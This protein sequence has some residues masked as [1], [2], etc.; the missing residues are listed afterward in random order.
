MKAACK[1]RCKGY[2]N[3]ISIRM[4]KYFALVSIVSALSNLAAA[5]TKGVLKLH[6]QNNHYFLYK[7]KPTILVGSGEHYGAVLNLDFNYEKYLVSLAKDGLNTT[8]IFTGNYVEKSGD[9]GIQKNTLAPQSGSFIAPWKRSSVSGY[10]L[11][12]NKFD[13]EKWDEAYFKRLK[14][15][16]TK[17]GSKGIIVEITLFSSYYGKGWENS[18]LNH[19]NN[20]NKT[21]SIPAV[22]VNTLKNKNVIKFQEKFVRK[23]VREL[24][25]FDNLYFEIQNEPWA[26]FSETVIRRDDYGDEKDWRSTFQVVS[27]TSNE[28]QKTVASWI[29]DE[30]RILPNRHLISQNI[31]NFHYPIT[32]PD[33][34]VS[35]FN[36]HYAL[37]EAVKENYYLNKVIGF[38]ETG[39]AGKTDATYRKQAWRFLMSGGALFNHLDYSFAV[40]GEGGQD[41]VYKAPGG[42]SPTLRNELGFLKRFFESKNFINF[43]PD[44]NFVPSSPGAVALTLSN[45]TD[46]WIVYVEPVAPN[47]SS[48]TLNLPK[49][50]YQVDWVDAASGK[51]SEL[52]IITNNQVAVPAGL[53]DKVLFIRLKE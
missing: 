15:F 46:T 8:R 32:N 36:F 7:E 39:F 25:N 52:G 35:I 24:N 18:P 20:I 9:F 48:L 30:E 33:P 51:T 1:I 12:G 45:T 34:N 27:K 29:K 19:L 4:L 2:S 38:N 21:D 49:G 10:T 41:T 26:E 17:A 16:M 47:S 53:N 44:N 5:Q 40:E 3:L 28:W 6:P 50:K 31:S 13:L 43:Q 14:D 37:P 42:G 22:A 23:I 11:G